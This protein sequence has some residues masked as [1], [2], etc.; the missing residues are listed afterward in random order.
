MTFRSGVRGTHDSV[1]G[2]RVMASDG[3]AGR[4]SWASYAP[5]ES[6]LVVTLGLI[7]RKHHVVPAGAVTSVED[8]EVRVALS[9]AQIRQLHD[10]PQPH[11]AADPLTA[12]QVLTSAMAAWARTTAGGGGAGF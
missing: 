11:L 7:S 3:R 8:G 6:F 10:V 9:R 1:K 4:V 2:F 5:D 12:D